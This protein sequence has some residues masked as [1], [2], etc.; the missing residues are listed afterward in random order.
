MEL[1]N[2]Q[3]TN[4]EKPEAEGEHRTRMIFSIVASPVFIT[5]SALHSPRIPAQSFRTAPPAL[6]RP[7]PKSSY[8][9]ER[10][11]H[12][13]FAACISGA[14]SLQYPGRKSAWGGSAF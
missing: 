12:T 13:L 11:A 9:L 3:E 7:V 6:H 5:H 10:R 4:W 14:Y 1:A 2:K 8:C